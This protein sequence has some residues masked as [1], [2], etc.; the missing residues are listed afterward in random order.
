MYDE[1]IDQIEGVNHV[2]PLKTYPMMVVALQSGDVDALTAELP[3]A[4]GIVSS[5]PDLVMVRFSAENGFEA[6]T[7]VSI[8]V[9]EG[10]TEL[11]NAVQAALDNISVEDRVQMMADATNRQPAVEE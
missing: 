9:Q 4:Q 5:N 2:T 3:V 1:V 11:L 6:D 10:N 7:T 8:A